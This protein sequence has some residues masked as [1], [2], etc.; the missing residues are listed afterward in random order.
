[1]CAEMSYAPGDEP[2]LIE[3]LVIGESD[4]IFGAFNDWWS[5]PRAG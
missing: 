5:M 2:G 4:R 3:N 1:M